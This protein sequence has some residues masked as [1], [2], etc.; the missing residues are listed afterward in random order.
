METHADANVRDSLENDT[1]APTSTATTP[2]AA[3]TATPKEQRGSRSSGSGIPAPAGARQK[4]KKNKKNKPRK[5]RASR[6]KKQDA[7]Q[8]DERDAAPTTQVTEQTHD[9]STR[10][11]VHVSISEDSVDGEAKSSG[12]PD[13]LDGDAGDGVVGDVGGEG[14]DTV[15]RAFS[16]PDDVQHGHSEGPASQTQQQQQQEQQQEGQL[17]QEQEQEEEEQEQDRAGKGRTASREEDTQS[18]R[19]DSASSTTSVFHEGEKSTIRVVVRVRPLNSGELD[20]GEEDAV[21]VLDDNQTVGVRSEVTE[22]ITSYTFHQAQGSQCDQDRFFRNCGIRQLLNAAMEGFSCTAFAYGQTGSGKTHTLTGPDHDDA[23]GVIQ[24]S[25]RYIWQQVGRRKDVRFK[26]RASYLEIYNEQ[27][28][29]LMNLPR[30]PLPV[31][32]SAEAGFHVDNLFKI[33]CDSEDAMLAVLEEGLRSRRI[34]AHDMNERSSRG[35]TILTLEIDSMVED[36]DVDVLRRQ[37]R[38]SFVDLAGSERLS[39]TKSEGS[40]LVES[41]NINKSLLTLGNCIS[42]LAD[43]RKRK[44]YIPYR[45]SYLT[46]LLKD[47]LGGTGMT[48]MI[49]CVSPAKDSLQETKNTLRYASRAKRIQNKPIVHMDP[50]QKLI[51]ALKREVRLLRAECAYMREQAELS[52]GGAVGTTLPHNYK[53]LKVDGLDEG[54]EMRGIANMARELTQAKVYLQQ[55][56]RENEDLRSENAQLLS[57]KQQLEQQYET[58]RAGLP[59]RGF[60]AAGYAATF[61]TRA[62]HRNGGSGSG[63]ADMGAGSTASSQAASSFSSR[64]SSRVP[65]HA[66]GLHQSAN[67]SSLSVNSMFHGFASIT[68]SR[69]TTSS[70][71]APFAPRHSTPTKSAYSYPASGYSSRTGTNTTLDT[72]ASS[73]SSR[74]TPG[75][76]GRAG[77]SKHHHS[78]AHRSHPH[79]PHG[80]KQASTLSQRQMARYGA[81]APLPPAAHSSGA[82]DR[83]APTPELR[84]GRQ[85]STSSLSQA[86]RRVLEKEASELDEIDAQIAAM[87]QELGSH[88]R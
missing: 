34:A 68:S 23:T 82:R 1:E 13:E 85:G 72:Y 57:S 7:V 33:T 73:A 2:T 39:R 65:S 48:L 4:S 30:G 43:P 5:Q 80:S 55:L 69:A 67:A 40:T 19:P 62:R 24:R 81:P 83:L 37:G 50:V 8:D 31:R 54:Q 9:A 27:V 41:H 88:A 28:F 63:S 53:D 46:M 6:P 59:V 51:Q 61:A 77:R 36:V 11:R 3:A 52:G 16:N 79:P 60:K 84:T 22:S 75:S 64:L 17:Q 71:D 87:Q 26:F 29:D 74:T 38:V 10:G 25:I 21:Y 58:R 47:S 49:A 76:R 78:R 45:D 32:W 66:S 15:V 44:A 70:L 18:A 20:R 14:D 12:T 42:A 56:M 86:A 35:H